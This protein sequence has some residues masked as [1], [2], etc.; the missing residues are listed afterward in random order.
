VLVPSNRKAQAVERE[1]VA[2]EWTPIGNGGRARIVAVGTDTGGIVDID[3]IDLSRAADRRAYALRA[4]AQ[5]G[6]LTV[7]QVVD[8]LLRIAVERCNA[9]A[10]PEAP[11]PTLV[12]ALDEWQTHEA[13]PTVCTGFQPLDALAG[14][15]LPGGLPLGTITVLLGPPAAGKSALALQCVVGALLA[16]PDL[17]A[18]WAAGE[19]SRTALAARAIAVGSVLIGGGKPV[20]KDQ[21]ERRRPAAKAVADELRQ[22]IAERLVMVPPVLTPDRIEQVVVAS[23]AKLVCIDYLQLVRLDGAA[24]ART[25]VDGVMARLRAMSLQHSVAVLLISN[26]GKGIDASSRIGSLGK[27]SS[28]IDFDA[29]LVLLGQAAAEKGEDNTLP[30]EWLCKKHRHGQARDLRTLF[31]GDLQTFTD[32]E[33]AEPFPEFLNHAPQGAR[34]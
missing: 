26:I 23:G 22:R 30:V 31:D 32:A 8:K 16:D 20:T 19:M 33:A 28:Q 9:A 27:H 13:V 17:R 34:R 2:L 25:E 7:P 29:D 18:I 1:A 14:G 12:D 24:D 11:A 21:A 6:K 4:V 10:E 3:T 5:F 15:N